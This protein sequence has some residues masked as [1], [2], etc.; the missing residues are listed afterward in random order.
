[1]PPRARTPKKPAAPVV[2][3]P[4]ANGGVV[5]VVISSEVDPDEAKIELFRIDDTPY[6]VPARPSMNL[7]LAFV[8]DV[9]AMGTEIANILLLERLVGPTA[10][11][12]L[13]ACQSLKP[14]QL[15]AIAD[16]ASTLALG[17]VEEAEVSGN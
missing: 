6:L 5:P 14:A 1:M 3:A 10:F 12:A 4:A 11:A 7:V 9:Q 13:S 8:K 17:V 16:A 2:P 15:A